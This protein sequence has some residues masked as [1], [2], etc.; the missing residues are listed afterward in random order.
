MFSYW[1]SS[2]SKIVTADNEVVLNMELKDDVVIKEEAIND[3]NNEVV[4]EVK[5]ENMV[6]ND[7][8]LKVDSETKKGILK[9]I[10]RYILIGGI[11]Q[12]NTKKLNKYNEECKILSKGIMNGC[13]IDM[14]NLLVEIS[15]NGRAMKEQTIHFVLAYVSCLGD[16]ETRSYAYTQLSKIC[17][18]PTHLFNYIAYRNEFVGML[19]PTTIGGTMTHV[20]VG[21]GFPMGLRKAISNW[22]NE[23]TPTE[24]SYMVVKYQ[25]RRIEG[26]KTQWTHY[27]VA[28]MAH[29]KPAT[30]LH[31][32]IL[33]FTK[34]KGLALIKAIFMYIKS[35]DNELALSLSNKFMLMMVNNE[36]IKLEELQQTVEEE[37]RCITN[38]V[39]TVFKIL[40]K[41][42]DK[43]QKEAIKN[44]LL[45]FITNSNDI[46]VDSKEI[47]KELSKL[48]S[49]LY[50]IFYTEYLPELTEK[51]V[52]K[53]LS[54]TNIPT[55]AVPNIW[56]KEYIY[57]KHAITK[58][59]LTRLMRSLSVL[60]AHKIIDNDFIH[61][62]VIDKLTNRE[63]IL[64]SR[65]HPVS[66][67]NTKL[68][69]DSGSGIKGSL[70]W[71]VNKEVSD[72][73]DKMITLSFLNSPEIMLEKLSVEGEEC[74][75][76]FSIDVS[77]SMD[78][79][80]MLNINCRDLASLICLMVIKS[81]TK[82]NK[83][84]EKRIMVNKFSSNSNN[85]GYMSSNKKQE[86]EEKDDGLWKVDFNSDMTVSEC[87]KEINKNNDN[88]TSTD[89]SL[90]ITTAM[91]NKNR[92]K[93]FIVITD[94]DTNSNKRLPSE[95]LKIYREKMNIPNAQLIVV[96][97]SANKF[98]IADPNDMGMLDICGADANISK[99]IV[100]F[101]N[102]TI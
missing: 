40:F 91:K 63:L 56:L 77:P 93:T 5:E 69:Y 32:I 54:K 23:K 67:I 57:W 99:L 60:S 53:I 18:T 19:R 76:M 70:E 59:P 37:Y 20:L 74:D 98:T 62:T 44:I 71:E 61:K 100:D 14:V 35:V 11:N 65:I 83:E 92:I 89:C 97:L 8:V 66:V 2:N 49:F 68:T 28:S 52:K 50:I 47:S 101:I 27:D 15:M 4:E 94:N 72:A 41:N 21:K 102:E 25:G 75:I 88:W 31:S 13:G 80:A 87:I 34:N 46:K 24:L 58:T 48:V 38:N 16:D 39:Y 1:F 78:A 84:L 10:E 73:L 51:Y 45:K 3:I 26:A 22:Y 9:M 86:E 6:N 43:R 55:E 79:K 85:Y 7:L 17:R 30:I 29:I 82:N 90:P 36:L 12:Y 33:L 96:A 64:N 95:E 81:I 42:D